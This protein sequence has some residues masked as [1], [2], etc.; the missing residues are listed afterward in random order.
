MDVMSHKALA[1]EEVRWA[2]QEGAAG[3]QAEAEGA[4]EYGGIG[5]N[6]CANSF[7]A[8]QAEFVMFQRDIP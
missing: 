1:P 6:I 8:N 7:G 4:R 3:E 5:G 2:A